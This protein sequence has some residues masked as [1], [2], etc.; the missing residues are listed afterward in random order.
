MGAGATSLALRKAF[1]ADAPAG[2]A[3]PNII[4]IVSDDQGYADVGVHGCKDIPTPNIDR[5]ASEGV[6]F[7]NGYVS[8]PVCSPTRAGIMTGRYQQRFGHWFNPGPPAGQPTGIGLPLSEVTLAELLKQA[9]YATGMVGKW[10]LGREEQFHPMKRG[11][12]QYFGFLHGSHSYLNAKADPNNLILAG[13]EPVDEKEY[14]TDAFGREAVKFIEQD[15]GKPFFLYL[16]FNAVHTPLDA[17]QKYLDRFPDI[18]DPMRK[19][20]AAMLSAMDDAIGGVLEALQ[21]K[22]VDNNTLIFFVSDNGGPVG[23]N[24]SCNDPLAGA[25]S[26]LWEGGIRVPFFMRWPEQIK[27]GTVCDDPVI[28]LDFLPTCV[29][30][31]GGTLPADRKIDGVDILPYVTGQKSGEP[32]ECLFWATK[33]RAMRKGH[34]KILK[35]DDGAFRLYNLKDDI[36]EKTDLA[37]KKPEK[38][39]EMKAFLA[40]WESELKPPLWAGGQQRAATAKKRPAAKRKEGAPAAKKRKK[41]Q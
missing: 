11:F 23:K 36:G 16:T 27:A 15:H 19:K 28:S 1:A 21:K 7:T 2:P 20:Y 41:Q 39:E 3:R 37:E 40:Q 38:V 4:V 18:S 33:D 26:T 8:C 12:D 22:G 35:Q 5:L 14:L 6:R 32:H 24:G 29:A 34:W 13:T 17:I 31:A 10:H 30:A 9:G 25:K